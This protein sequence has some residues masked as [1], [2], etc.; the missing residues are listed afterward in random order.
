LTTFPTIQR[1]SEGLR[2]TGA[3]SEKLDW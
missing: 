1:R 2:F 3:V